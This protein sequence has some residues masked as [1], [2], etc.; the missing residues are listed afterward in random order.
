VWDT[1][2]N[3]RNIMTGPQGA[4]ARMCSSLLASQTA[5]ERAESTPFSSPYGTVLRQLGEPSLEFQT[6][7]LRTQATFG[8]VVMEYSSS[9]MVM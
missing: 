8:L 3:S 2:G 7:T 4:Q 6:P 1:T 5:A 9:R